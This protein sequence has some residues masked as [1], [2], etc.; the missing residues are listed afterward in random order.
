MNAVFPEETVQLSKDGFTAVK[1]YIGKHGKHILVVG[2][3]AVYILLDPDLRTPIQCVQIHY[4][5][6]EGKTKESVLELA[7]RIQE[8]G[9]QVRIRQ[10]GAFFIDTFRDEKWNPAVAVCPKGLRFR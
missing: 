9:E 1:E 8:T 10:E 4:D 7:N 3:M 6:N 5:K 2:D